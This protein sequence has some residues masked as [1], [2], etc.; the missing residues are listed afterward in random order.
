MLNH[1][2]KLWT[3]DDERYRKAGERREQHGRKAAEVERE[4]VRELNLKPITK[5]QE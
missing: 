5:D 3:W 4:V 2:Q 1:M